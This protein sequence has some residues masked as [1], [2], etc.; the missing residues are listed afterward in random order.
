MGAHA[1]RLLYTL[2]ASAALLGGICRVD[3]FHSLP[4]ACCLAS[5]DGEEVT[6]PGIVNTRVPAR[7]L[8]GPAVF[9]AAGAVWLWL[10]A[11]TQGGRLDRLNVDYVVPA[12]EGECRLVVEVAALP[13][14][15]LLLLG[16]HL[17]GLLAAVAPLLPAGDAVLGLLELLLSFPVVAWV[18]HDVA[19]RGDQK[20][21]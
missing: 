18:L 1:Q 21:L 8:A 17:H 2:P 15:L 7:L 12:H 19:I 6:P 14:H 4:G 16:E 5:E 10:R 9:V 20:N 3:R 13:A 11:A